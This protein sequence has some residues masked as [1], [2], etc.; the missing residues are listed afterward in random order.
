MFS[1]T[2]AT[3]FLNARFTGYWSSTVNDAFPLQAWMAYTNQAGAMF[4]A[5]RD[6]IVAVWPVRGGRR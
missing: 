6:G 1:A 4:S 2:G 3:S 5:G